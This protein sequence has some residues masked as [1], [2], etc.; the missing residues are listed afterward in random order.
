M[1]DIAPYMENIIE[2][3]A[4]KSFLKII[5]SFKANPIAGSKENKEKREGIRRQ[6]REKARI[7]KIWNKWYSYYKGEINELNMEWFGKQHS[8]EIPYLANYG[9]L[10]ATSELTGTKEEKERKAKALMNSFIDKSEPFAQK[11]EKIIKKH[12]KLADDMIK[13]GVPDFV[14]DGGYM[15]AVYRD[16][17]IRILIYKGIESAKHVFLKDHGIT[18]KPDKDV[19]PVKVEDY[20]SKK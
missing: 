14:R 17:M 20:Y 19:P 3:G 10:Y 13:S 9:A 18:V 5:E 11:E 16:I 1:E 8:G 4:P 6:E 2:H 12:I 15:S 7:N